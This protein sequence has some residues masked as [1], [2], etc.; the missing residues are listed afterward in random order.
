ML[1]P[2][3]D[4]K[5]LPLWTRL[6]HDT[7]RR[8]I[9][10]LLIIV[11]LGI[12]AFVLRLLYNFTAGRLT[13]FIKEWLGEIP[14]YAVPLTAV[15]LL[16]ALLYL[17]GLTAG[18]VVGR[19]FIALT[20][21]LIRRIPL[22]KSVYGASKQVVESLSLQD[23]SGDE[24]VAALIEFPRPGMK[25]VGFV[26]GKAQLADGQTYYRVFIPT[27]P[28][29][30]VGLFELVAPNDLQFC[31]LSVEEAVKMVVSGGILG[32]EIL[33]VRSASRGVV[34]TPQPVDEEEEETE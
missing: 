15:I 19:Q 8:L 3:K 18:V 33:K 28:N 11:P 31:A 7:R 24:R 1:T 34:D 2:R 13:P 20:E 5:K 12:T 25:T 30:T 6:R 23:K 22:V 21:A 14:E 29:V 27:T 32:P 16:F 4:R 10:G 9:S 26:T 17:V